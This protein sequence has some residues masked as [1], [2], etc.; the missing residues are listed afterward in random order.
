MVTAQQPMRTILVLKTNLSDDFWY[1][2]REIVYPKILSQEYL[3]ESVLRLPAPGIG[4][5][6]DR[7]ATT[8]RE[9]G[10][11]HGT[12]SVERR[13]HLEPAFIKVAEVRRDATGKPHVKVEFL[14]RIPGL[15]S[16]VLDR[17]LGTERWV[18]AIPVETWAQAQGNL[19]VRPPAEWLSLLELAES[20]PTCRDF[21][22]PRFLGLLESGTNYRTCKEAVANTLVGVG[23]DV[24]RLS[25]V[26]EGEV[27]PNGFASTPSGERFGYWFVYNCKSTPFALS[28]DEARRTKVHIVRCR[29]ELPAVKAVPADAGRFMFVAPNFVIT[30]D[31]AANIEDIER[32]THCKGALVTFEGL[33]F[34]LTRK[35]ALGYR[36]TFAEFDKLFASS[37]V[38]DGSAID[39]TFR[40]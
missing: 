7:Q 5:F 16:G 15:E 32:A 31:L 17:A 37:R 18:S 38:M 1:Q 26:D 28:Q 2:A 9:S 6:V 40:T 20:I 24:T 8:H 3:N 23:F 30:R 35:L 36:F 19:D 22:G 27:A 33:L 21:L 12:S 10:V 39:N 25:F 4:L 14:T 29:R 13:S 34:A 11:E